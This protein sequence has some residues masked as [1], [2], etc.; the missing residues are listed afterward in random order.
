M[1]ASTR[2][3]NEKLDSFFF[4]FND[5]VFLEIFYSMD[6]TVLLVDIDRYPKPCL[7]V[8]NFALDDTPRHFPLRFLISRI[9]QTVPSPLNFRNDRSFVNLSASRIQPRID[10][11]SREMNRLAAADPFTGGGGGAA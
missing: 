5:K 3:K 6:E 8:E 11:R 1:D 9:C 4:F 10:F 7:G 2:V